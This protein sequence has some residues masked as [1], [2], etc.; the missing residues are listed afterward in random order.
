VRILLVTSYSPFPV[1]RGRDRLIKSLIDGL[2]VRHEV[3]LATMA[4]DETEE[5]ALAEGGAAFSIRS[6]KAPNR[7]SVI[8]RG[9]FKLVNIAGALVTLVPPEVSY[10]RPLAFVR[11]VR[12]LCEELEP[13]LVLVNY[14][15]LYDLPRVLRSR[16]VVL[17]THD[18]DYLVSAERTRRISGFFKRTVARIDAVFEERIERRAYSLYDSILTLTKRDAGAVVEAIGDARKTVLPLPLAIDLRRYRPSGLE[19]DRETILFFGAFD[20]DFN[21]DALRFLARDI[22]PEVR[23]LRPGCRCE[24]VGHGLEAHLRRELPPGFVYRGGVEDVRPHLAACTCAVLPLRFGGGVRIRMME[25]AAMGTPVVST[26]A[27]VAGMGLQAGRDYL[28]ASDAPGFARAI[29]DLIEDER[30]AAAIGE[31]ARRWACET[32]SMDDY[33]DRLDA[34]LS[35][36]EKRL[37]KKLG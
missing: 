26:P 24:L 20:A 23:R 25:A 19:R 4:L 18:V 1:R 8:H 22:F 30:L 2:A 5:R 32:I 27:G 36:L 28:E 37:S 17:I 33:P 14:W 21:R 12:R 10:A 34:C 15:H 29:L 9:W 6:I 11:H 35:L 31:S 16:R 3:T 13:E 7:R